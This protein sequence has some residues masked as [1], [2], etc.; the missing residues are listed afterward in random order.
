MNV[1]HV[2]PYT[3]RVLGGHANAIRGF[4]ACQRAKGINAVGIAPKP[5]A[6][7]PEPDWGFPV[8]EVDSLWDLRWSS[9]AE[10]FVISPDDSL[11]HL[12][13][14]NRRYAPLLR[15]LRQAG[16]PYVLTTHGQLAF[17]TPWHWLK[18]FVY[19]NLVNRDPAKAAGL[20]ALTR[21]AARRARFLMPGFRGAVLVQG[22]L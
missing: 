10:R 16:V 20:H 17:Q 12:H 3:A 8:A 11:L 13:G 2:F 22:N 15:G 18:K 21:F 9:V 6:R 19:L 4:I 5:D 14:V 7:E 1:V